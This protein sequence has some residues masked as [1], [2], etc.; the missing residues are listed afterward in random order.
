MPG[1]LVHHCR[2]SGSRVGAP[3]QLTRPSSRAAYLARTAAVSAASVPSGSTRRS[4]SVFPAAPWKR[5][6][7]AIVVV[8]APEA[9]LAAA[10][11]QHRCRLARRLRPAHRERDQQGPRYAPPRCRRSGWSGCSGRVPA[12]R[13][14]ARRPARA[15]RRRAAA[16]S[17]RGTAPQGGSASRP[18]RCRARHGRARAC[19]ARPPG[20]PATLR[21]GPRA[22]ARRVPRSPRRHP[23]TEAIASSTRAAAQGSSSSGSNCAVA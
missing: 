21:R 7:A 16:R 9:V 10:V 5:A 15:W 14:R 11:A 8:L 12:A 13:R 18:V 1:A 20:G 17:R 4:A 22:Q 23:R 19:A 6:Q 2:R 3:G